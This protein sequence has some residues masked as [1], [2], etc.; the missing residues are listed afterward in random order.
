M[1]LKQKFPHAS[2]QFINLNSPI[3]AAVPQR[4]A[5]TTLVKKGQGK[6]TIRGRT[7]VCYRGFFVRPLDT[8][9]LA[10][11]TKQI[12]DTLTRCGLLPADDPYNLSIQWEQEKVVHFADERLEITITKP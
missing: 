12:T 5:P 6:G 3:P 8:D 2:Q 10:A 9:N 4:D 7:R 11:G 1:N